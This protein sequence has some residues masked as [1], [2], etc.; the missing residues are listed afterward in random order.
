VV[1]VLFRAI[2]SSHLEVKEVAREGL[3][4]VLGIQGRLPRDL[5]HNGLKPVLNNLSDANKLSLTGLEGLESLLG[6]L[7]TSFKV[8][9]GVKLLEHF[10]HLADPQVLKAVVGADVEEIKKLVC[11][12]NLFHLL[13]PDA[14]VYLEDLVNAVM[15]AEAYMNCFESSPFTIPLGRY[16]NQYAR[17]GSQFFL[18][19]LKLQ[20]YFRALRNIVRSGIAPQFAL[21]LASSTATIIA[22]LHTKTDQAAALQLCVDLAGLFPFWLSEN[23]TLVDAVVTVWRAERSR[24]TSLITDDRH[25]CFLMLSIFRHALEQS[26]RIDVLFELVSIYSRDLVDVVEY[27][28]FVYKHVAMDDSL[29]FRRNILGRFSKWVQSDAV[30]AQDKQ[31]FIRFIVTPMLLVQAAREPKQGLV[32][33]DLIRCLMH[34]FWKPAEDED[35]VSGTEP[36]LSLEV[37]H[38]TSVIVANFPEQLHP[39][40][41]EL[42]QFIVAHLTNADPVI[43]LTA[44]WLGAQFCAAFPPEPGH[45]KQA[46][47]LMTIYVGLLKPQEVE[48]KRTLLDRAHEAIAV[49]IPALPSEDSDVPAWARTTRRM[50]SEEATTAAQISAIYHFI[51]RQPDVFYPVRS[52][53]LTAM[54]NASNR[55]GSFGGQLPEARLLSIEIVETIFKWDRKA[56]DEARDTEGMDMD[57]DG[58]EERSEPLTL[59]LT[60]REN[61]VSY[62]VRL[63]CISAQEVTPNPRSSSSTFA[64][65]A[66]TMIRQLVGPEGWKDVTVKLN[67]FSRALEQVREP[68][69]EVVLC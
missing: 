25:K 29:A 69:P 7:T 58:D 15:Q 8:E 6:I 22:S 44:H 56:R 31:S 52:L 4:V 48:T 65:R 17:T 40:R 39:W 3:V 20:G 16:L 13:P 50:L 28:R 67:Y 47:F 64:P 37:L 30:P 66:L 60:L 34:C 53:F 1:H 21:Q 38:L 55:L 9:L 27:T 63:A 18:R 59:S 45:P 19:N 61:V 26:P 2:Y 42:A 43:K 41:Q 12:A 62:L 10:R 57:D 5:L 49:A 23:P 35:A 32:D 24:Q 68:T 36:A 33:E 14:G 54:V 11:L 46:K 51:V